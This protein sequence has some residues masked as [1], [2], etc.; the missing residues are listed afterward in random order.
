MFSRVTQGQRPRSLALLMVVGAVLI[1]VGLFAAAVFASLATD[2]GTGSPG[3][4][5]TCDVTVASNTHS[6]DCQLGAAGGFVSYIGS[7][8]TVRQSSGTGLFD[9]FVRLQGS[10][11]EKG[12]NTCSQSHFPSTQND[13]CPGGNVTQ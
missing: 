6:A 3:F 4:T 1:A 12:Y 5:G 8:D 7:S 2:T 9:P 13:I 11:T 10:P